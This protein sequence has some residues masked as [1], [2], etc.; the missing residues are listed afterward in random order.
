MAANFSGVTPTLVT[1]LGPEFKNLITPGTGK[2][3]Y[4][5]LDPN[6][7]MKYKLEW[8][9]MSN[10]NF[11]TLYNHV[12]SCKG[13]FDSFSWKSVPL[14]I[15]TNQDS[16]E[17]GADLTGRWVEGTFKFKPNAKSWDAEIVFEKAL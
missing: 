17:D 8:T 9:M 16:V 4:Q 2:K 13:G 7:V 15:D 6:P 3:Q 11:W 12:Y 5:N 1:P 10:A 14:Y